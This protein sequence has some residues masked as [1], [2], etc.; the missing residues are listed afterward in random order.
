MCTKTHVHIIRP[1]VKILVLHIFTSIKAFPSHF[2]TILLNLRYKLTNALKV[3]VFLSRRFSH[4][5]KM[6]SSLQ[7]KK[8]KLNKNRPLSGVTR[9]SGIQKCSAGSQ[10]TYFYV[11]REKYSTHPGGALGKTR[12]CRWSD[13]LGRRSV[14]ATSN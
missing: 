3:Y 13:H 4:V 7:K 10:R 5:T 6:S 9:A 8:K 1:F 12:F 2:L 14:P 11:K